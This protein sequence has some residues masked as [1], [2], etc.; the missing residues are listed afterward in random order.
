MIIFIIIIFSF[1][2]YRTKNGDKAGLYLQNYCLFG[3]GGEGVV[4]ILIFSFSFFF[5]SLI[6]VP[7]HWIVTMVSALIILILFFGELFDYRSVHVESSLVVDSGRKEKM[8]IDFDITFRKIPCYSTFHFIG[9]FSLSL[10]YG[11]LVL[12]QGSLTQLE[13][14]CFLPLRL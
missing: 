9:C 3:G 10:S 14:Y 13:I 8:D 5:A 6:F 11:L 1:H 4:F 12:F 2:S 7:M